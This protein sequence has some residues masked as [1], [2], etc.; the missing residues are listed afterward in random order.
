MR[1]VQRRPKRRNPLLAHLAGAPPPLPEETPPLQAL[2]IVRKLA[3]ADVGFSLG[4]LK[5][6]ICFADDSVVKSFAGLQFWRL[7]LEPHFV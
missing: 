7:I 6:E 3:A 5:L 4:E 2:L 1:S